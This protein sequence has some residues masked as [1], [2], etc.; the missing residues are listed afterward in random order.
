MLGW[1]LHAHAVWQKPGGA[2]P[3]TVSAAADHAG[4]TPLSVGAHHAEGPAVLFAFY[5][6]GIQN[7]EARGLWARSHKIQKLERDLL[8]ILDGPDGQE[9]DAVFFCEFGQMWKTTISS[10]LHLHAGMP[11]EPAGANPHHAGCVREAPTD[12]WIVIK[13]FR[14][15]L[16]RLQI[17]HW[18]VYADAPYVALVATST[19]KV[20]LHE[21]VSS[22]CSSQEQR[23]QHLLLGH[24]DTDHQ[25]RVFNC[26]MP[27]SIVNTPTK[28]QDTALTMLRM[29]TNPVYNDASQPPPAWIIGGDL[30]ASPWLLQWWSQGFVVP[31]KECLSRTGH[32][33]GLDAQKSDFALSQGIT[34]AHCTSYVGWHSKPCASDVHDCVFLRGDLQIT[35]P[36]QPV[37]AVPAPPRRNALQAELPDTGRAAQAQRTTE[38]LPARVWPTPDAQ[39]SATAGSADAGGAPAEPGAPSAAA[40]H[41]SF[42]LY[43]GEMYHTWAHHCYEKRNCEQNAAEDWHLPLAPGA[44]RVCKGCGKP[45]TREQPLAARCGE[46][47]EPV[48]SLC[49]NSG[50][51]VACEAE[52][53][54][55]KKTAGASNA[56]EPAGVSARINELASDADCALAAAPKLKARPPK[57]PTTIRAPIDATDAAGPPTPAGNVAQ[58]AASSPKANPS[59]QHQAQADVAAQEK[60]LLPTIAEQMQSLTFMDCLAEHAAAD[61]PAADNVL[62]GLLAITGGVRMKS[63]EDVLAAHVAITRRRE[64]FVRQ[65]ACL[66][67]VPQP[68]KGEWTVQQWTNWLNTTPLEDWIMDQAIK[69]WKQDF[70]RWDFNGWQEVSDLRRKDTR[71]DKEKARDL[72]NGAWKSHLAGSCG[73]HQLA[74]ALLKHPS[75]TVHTLL[76]SWRNYMASHEYRM[77]KERAK[78]YRPGELTPEIRKTRQEQRALK[79]K[80]QQLRNLRRRIRWYKKKVEAGSLQEIPPQYRVDYERFISGDFDRALD[81][82][83]EEHRYG[84]LR[85]RPEHLGPLGFPRSDP[86]V[87]PAR[88]PGALTGAVLCGSGDLHLTAC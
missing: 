46:C 4:D 41:L 38:A 21:R 86:C 26:H 67:G 62:S 80:L 9:V 65:F 29:C 59:L 43:C 20:L 81:A 7:N 85:T 88:P 70:E 36:P 64:E 34:L 15:L 87:T 72:V 37:A 6:V 60:Q 50:A 12:A 33:I 82:L 54:T 3:P 53:A 68:A 78:R 66:H 13:F 23:A 79:L 22:M 57:P 25:V 44:Q 10:E 63:K 2:P 49:W 76:E 48:H 14:D 27:T 83:T 40:E 28:K 84:Q 73:R 5:N 19:W 45:P 51:C 18:E 32:P 31:H 58:L 55:R 1:R 75:A 47:F 69:A 16:R 11:E 30:N 52:D 56:A 39:G 61:D 77:Q 8:R 24:V 17:D 71:V 35:E 74:T 42:C